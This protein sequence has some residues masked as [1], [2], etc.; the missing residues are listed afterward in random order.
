MN[1]SNIS[2]KVINNKQVDR[3]QSSNGTGRQIQR[4]GVNVQ[5][6]KLHI[7]KQRNVTNASRNQDFDLNKTYIEHFGQQI[8]RSGAVSN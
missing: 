6:S 3:S 1:S 7:F 8:D 5:N 4:S 2:I